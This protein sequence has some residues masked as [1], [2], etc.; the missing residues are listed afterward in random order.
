MWSS[1]LLASPDSKIGPTSATYYFGFEP[2]KSI[3]NV[4]EESGNS[5]I[6]ARPSA[7][8]RGAVNFGEVPELFAPDRVAGRKASQALTDRRMVQ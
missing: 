4:P 5:L 1:K 3:R 8:R 2:E 6:L 7:C